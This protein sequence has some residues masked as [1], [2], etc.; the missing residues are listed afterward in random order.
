MAIW[1]VKSQTAVTVELLGRLPQ[2]D[3]GRM[4]EELKADPPA[5]T[6]HV[7]ASARVHSGGT[8]REHLVPFQVCPFLAPINL[9]SLLESLAQPPSEAFREVAIIIALGL[10]ETPLLAARNHPWSSPYSPSP[11]KN[12]TWLFQA[13]QARPTLSI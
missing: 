9:A 5:K 11:C 8:L 12:A 6:V 13:T 2:S 1:K 10:E 3:C 7:Q 4:A